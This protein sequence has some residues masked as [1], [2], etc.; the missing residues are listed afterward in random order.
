MENSRR[1]P[2]ML[3]SQKFPPTLDFIVRVQVV[4]VGRSQVQQLVVVCAVPQQSNSPTF[5]PESRHP[6]DSGDHRQRL[7]HPSSVPFAVETRREK[8]YVALSPSTS[9]TYRDQRSALSVVVECRQKLPKERTQRAPR[10]RERPFPKPDR[11]GN[12]L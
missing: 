8:R 7:Y 1:L 6:A 12:P 11:K 10:P 4:Q 9:S 5:P 3:N 2:R